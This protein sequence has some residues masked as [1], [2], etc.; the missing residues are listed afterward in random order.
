MWIKKKK[1]MSRHLKIKKEG[2]R[3]SCGGSAVKNPTRT[4]D[5]AG[6]IP[7]LAPWV[8]DLVLP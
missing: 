3:H 5:D 7:G 6:L 4:H 1:N 2:C 8:K